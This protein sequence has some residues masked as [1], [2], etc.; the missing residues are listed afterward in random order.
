MEWCL[1]IGPRIGV[2]IEIILVDS[3]VGSNRLAGRDIGHDKRVGGGS[4]ETVSA[5]PID[6]VITG[7]WNSGDFSGVVSVTD[8]LIF[9]SNNIT[10]GASGKD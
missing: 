5:G 3:E 4:N 9:I 1:L 2:K 8:S 10:V 7:C 6:E